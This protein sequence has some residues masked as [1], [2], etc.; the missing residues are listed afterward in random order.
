MLLVATHRHSRSHSTAQNQTQ[1][2][3]LR[4]SPELRTKIYGLVYASVTIELCDTPVTS[5]RKHRLVAEIASLTSVCRQTHSEAGP[6]VFSNV[7]LK[8]TGSASLE[9]VHILLGEQSACLRA[10][11]SLELSETFVGEVLGRFESTAWNPLY[12]EQYPFPYP[13][14]ARSDLPALEMVVLPLQCPSLVYA[15]YE[16]AIRSCFGDY[17]LQFVGT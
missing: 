9:D 10:V 7:V 2:P 6:F 12:R 8:T 5:V 17:K 11:R 1:S 16:R 15:R 13:T 3:L 14:F 4:L